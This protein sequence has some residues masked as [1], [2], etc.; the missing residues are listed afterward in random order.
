MSGIDKT[1]EK[2]IKGGKGS[3]PKRGRNPRSIVVIGRRWFHKGPGN[4]YFSAEM[5][6]DGSRVGKIDY[7]YGYGEQYLYSAFYWLA[8]NGYIHGFGK[9]KGVPW[10]WAQDN[11][12]KLEYS[13]AD[14][15]RKKDL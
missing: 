8:E 1:Y 5:I 14:V 4:T 11:G 13:A 10:R 6:V 7:E 3:K 15:A 12:I 2:L 9:E